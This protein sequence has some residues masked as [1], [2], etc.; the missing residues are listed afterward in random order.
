MTMAGEG[1]RF[2]DAGIKT[3]KPLIV[4]KDNP[5]FVNAAQSLNGI[6]I[7]SWTFVV[8][9]EHINKFHID[10][11][12]YKY[13]KDANVVSVEKTT[14]GAAH[15][16]YLGIISLINSGI[17]AKDDSVIIMDC[18]VIVEANNWKNVIT[19]ADATG[20]LL[21]FKSTDP[22]YSYIASKDN[23]VI[24]TAE[25]IVI[26]DNAITS[27]YFINRI[28]YFIDAFRD[29]YNRHT[30]NNEMTYKEMYMSI[31]Y[32]FIIAQ[33]H[34]VIYVPADKVTSLGT[35]EELSQA[36]V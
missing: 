9:K 36:K 11:I 24:S 2:S 15:T 17:A 31:L 12:I 33:Q 34:D 28:K 22:R 14:S 30:I 1:K 3:P 7:A 5:L 26:S 29:M 10:N 13:Y 18:D 6:D 20:V 23:K 21:T 27:P 32:N 19:S 16:A 4:Y 35:P 25:K 8:R